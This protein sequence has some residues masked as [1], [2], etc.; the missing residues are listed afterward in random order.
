MIGTVLLIVGVLLGVLVAL[1]VVWFV[2]MRTKWPPVRDFQRRVNRRVFNPRQMRTAGRPGAY[3]GIIRH[4][5]RRS[6]RSY[7]TPVVP[8]PTDDGFV[9][10]LPYGDRPDWVRNVLAAGRA[11]IVH[12]GEEFAVV[13]PE[14]CETVDSGHEFSASELREI[15]L[16]GNT[17]CL[18]VRKVPAP[19][20]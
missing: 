19:T 3:A 10:L 14:L 11:T 15:R 20:S 8:L 7:E 5:G 1:A 4:V 18:R 2:G 16:F 13:E 6:G 17:R 12:E 9:I